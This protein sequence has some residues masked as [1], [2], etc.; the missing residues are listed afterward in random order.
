MSLDLGE[1]QRDFKKAETALRSSTSKLQVARA[2]H[3][4]AQ[5]RFAVAK[6]ALESG[7]RAVLGQD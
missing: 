4:K 2:V 7:T 6:Q 3:S 5:E 1:L